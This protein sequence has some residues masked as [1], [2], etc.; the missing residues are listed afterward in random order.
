MGYF[1]NHLATLV[2]GVFSAILTVFWFLLEGSFPGSQGEYV[3]FVFLMAVPISWFITFTCWIAQKS[4]DYMKN[5]ESDHHNEEKKSLSESGT[6]KPQRQFYT[7]EGKQVNQNEI[8]EAQDE[9]TEELDKLRATV[10]IKDSEIERLKQEIAN[11][12]TLVQI[13]SLKSELANLKMLASERR[14]SKKD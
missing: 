5:M 1:Y 2:T 13:E 8:R 10:K 6:G 7:S 9:L 11:L 14:K 3:N 12:E 4:A